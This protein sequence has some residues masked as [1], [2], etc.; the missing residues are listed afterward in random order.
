MAN[1]KINTIIK[2]LIPIIFLL[3]KKKIEFFLFRRSLKRWLACADIIC[4]VSD[5][6]LQTLPVYSSGKKIIVMNGYEEDNILL[7]D[8][9]KNETMFIISMV[10][11]LYPQQDIDFMV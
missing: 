4:S 7:K 10:G 9:Q 5:A 11:S 1:L 3:S 6:V 8:R 2:F